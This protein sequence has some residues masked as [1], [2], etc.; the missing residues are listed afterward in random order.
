MDF[1]LWY[2]LTTA[3]EV[4]S[5]YHLIAFT[6]SNNVYNHER[7]DRISGYIIKD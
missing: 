2:N 6:E 4:A 5:N 3:S 1:H 7:R